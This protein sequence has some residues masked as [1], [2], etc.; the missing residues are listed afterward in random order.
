MEEAGDEVD[1][2]CQDEGAQDVGERGP[3]E[4]NVPDGVGGQIRVGD[5]EVMPMVKAW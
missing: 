3:A 5:L 4:C 2:G 1:D